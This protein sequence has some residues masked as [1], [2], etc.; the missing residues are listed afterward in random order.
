M[1]ISVDFSPLFSAAKRMGAASSDFRIQ[2]DS[3]PIDP[4]DIQLGLGKEIKLEDLES[5]QGLLS[6]KGRQVLLYIPD[7]GWNIEDVL[8]DGKKGRRFH[9][10]ECKTLDDMRARGRF[11]RYVVTNDLSGVF[12]V[13]GTSRMTRAVIE[14]KTELMVCRNCLEHLNYQG[15]RSKSKGEKYRNA[16]DFSILDF[17][18]R[19]SSFF[20]YLPKGF[21]TDV[22]TNGGYNDDWKRISDSLREAKGYQ[23]E[24]CGVVLTHLK[25]LVHV[26]HKNGVKTDNRPGNLQ[27]LCKLCHSQCP[28]HDHLFISHAERKLIT[29]ARRAQ[30]IGDADSWF[31]VFELADPGLHGIIHLCKEGAFP[32]PEIGLDV[33]NSAGEV[34]AY[35]D[36][37][38]PKDKVAI[39]ISAEDRAAATELGWTVYSPIEA[40]DQENGPIAR[41]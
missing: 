34:V 37:A 41:A 35:L 15:H 2:L 26:H 18:E 21:A 29:E 33:Q 22:G 30:G 10:A 32:Y 23:C 16:V 27:V 38:W 9:V 7:Q 19:F 12:S 8:I 14:G 3:A 1:P 25:N 28:S 4:I 13:H 6:Y 39:S 5:N 31:E 11:E 20:K 40:L 17:F 36:L 24:D